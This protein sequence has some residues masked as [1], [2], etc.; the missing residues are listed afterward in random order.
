MALVQYQVVNLRI[1]VDIRAFGLV[2]LRVLRLPL[3]FIIP[4]VRS[5]YNAALVDAVARD[6]PPFHTPSIKKQW[7]FII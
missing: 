2:I 3:T 1:V 4:S 7:I 5:W 6:W